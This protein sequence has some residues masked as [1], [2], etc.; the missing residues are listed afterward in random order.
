MSVIFPLFVYFNFKKCPINND[1]FIVLF[2]D[3]EMLFIASV[4]FP[5]R[6][7]PFILLHDVIQLSY[8]YF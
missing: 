1:V 7:I 3:E 6:I 8:F 2:S 4:L 5:P